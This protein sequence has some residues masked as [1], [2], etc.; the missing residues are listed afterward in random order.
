[1]KDLPPSFF[2][3][4]YRK[5][6]VP[7]VRSRLRTY[8]ELMSGGNPLKE[9]PMRVVGDASADPTEYFT[10]Y[11]AYAFWAAK[12][13]AS[14]GSN[15]KILDLGSPKMLTAMLSATNEVTSIVLADCGDQWSDTRYVLHDACDPLPF[16]ANSFDCLTSA[17]A[18]QL[19]GLGRYGDRVCGDCLL[20]FVGELDRVMQPNSDLFVSV[21]IGPNLL[22]YDNQWVF[23]LDTIQQIFSNWK[24]V[25]Y[26]VDQCSSPQSFGSLP[27]AERFRREWSRSES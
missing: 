16:E 10:H 9:L 2:E 14:T 5:L 24:M 21:S 25:E 26:V 19:I 18:L 15:R 11:D 17:A 23:G 7:M 13:V 12:V 1:M 8:R 4:A 6:R 27:P 22:S 20:N 3:R